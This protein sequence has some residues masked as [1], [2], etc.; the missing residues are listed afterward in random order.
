MHK[1]QKIL[2]AVLIGVAILF[3]N[4]APAHAASVSPVVTL[5]EFKATLPAAQANQVTGVYASGLFALPVVQQPAG[6]AGFVSSQPE[7]LTQFGLASDYGTTGLL[8]HNTLA[9]AHFSDLQAG[10]F[11]TVM[12]GD[13]R[14]AYFQITA[15]ERYQALQPT[16]PYSDFVNTADQSKTLSATDLF[17]H[18]YNGNGQ[19]VLQTCIEANGN[20]S[21]GRLFI[22]AEPANFEFLSIVQDTLI[23]ASFTSLGLAQD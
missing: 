4:F 23:A 14:A 11:L 18:V 1:I 16:S 9:G 5:S 3:A 13:G 20:P 22:I 2:L 17:N 19:L 21:W 8:A 7:V 15:V 12:Y 6:N 10:Q